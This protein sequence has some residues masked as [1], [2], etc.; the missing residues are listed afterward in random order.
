[1]LGIQ[2]LLIVFVIFLM[3]SIMLL[4]SFLEK[5]FIIT[6][7]KWVKLTIEIAN[8]LS[9]IFTTILGMYELKDRVLVSPDIYE[10]AE[11]YFRVYDPAAS[12][13][14]IE[15]QSRRTLQIQVI[16]GKVNTRSASVQR[17]GR[18]CIVT[19]DESGTAVFKVTAS[20]SREIN[21]FC[22]VTVV[23]IDQMADSWEGMRTATVSA[24]LETDC[25][26][27]EQSSESREEGGKVNFGI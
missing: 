8:I 17:N 24:A 14:Y 4:A 12:N 3:V 23:D 15:L 25:Q 26:R 27:R 11:R 16:Y 2:I 22:V 19:G 9:S 13:Q 20:Q 5:R 10:P 21:V 7:Q 1:M 6:S 18:S